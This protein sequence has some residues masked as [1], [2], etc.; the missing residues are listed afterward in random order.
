MVLVCLAS[1]FSIRFHF[2]HVIASVSTLSF[3]LLPNHISLYGYATFCFICLWYDG[4][5]GCLHF[6]LLW[7]IFLWRFVYK[8]SHGCKLLL[9][10]VYLVMHL[11]GYVVLLF[12]FVEI[13]N[14]FPPWLRHCTVP[15]LVCKG[16]VSPHSHQ[17][18][19]CL[20]LIIG[21]RAW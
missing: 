15:P 6:W 19:Y 7:I 16:S 5:L 3:F 1:S 4:H 10:H 8:F 11:L 12:N 13:T 14:S 9:L 2:L 21:I 17:H 18:C 20:F